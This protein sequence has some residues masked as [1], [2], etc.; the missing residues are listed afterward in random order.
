MNTSPFMQWSLCI[1]SFILQ[2]KPLEIS[3]S[4]TPRDEEQTKTNSSVKLQKTVQFD[5]REEPN[6]ASTIAARNIL[7]TTPDPSDDEGNSGE[8]KVVHNNEMDVD[9]DDN[10][11]VNNGL[12]Q[13]SV[14]EVPVNS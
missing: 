7:T 8:S 1:P 6:T 3:F 14:S 5:L 9:K 2:R 4:V 10:V 12:L 11:S 13:P